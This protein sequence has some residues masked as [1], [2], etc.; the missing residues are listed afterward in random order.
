MLAPPPGVAKA[1]PALFQIFVQHLQAVAAVSSWG[2]EGHQQ[3]LFLYL[4]QG[5]QA[6][7]QVPAGLLSSKER[8]G[9]CHAT[10]LTIV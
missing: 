4:A 8:F 7:P 3:A 2:S 5:K 9:F 10:P 1:F 6:H